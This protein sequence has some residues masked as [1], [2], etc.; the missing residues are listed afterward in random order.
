MSGQ[1]LQRFQVSLCQIHHVDVVAHTGTVGRGVVVAPDV[2]KLP[3]AH[4]HLR[5]KG[6]QVIGRALRVLPDQP[7]GVG[8]HRVEIT[9]Y[10]NAPIR[11]AAV[12]VA[13]HVLYHQLS[14]SVGVGGGQGVV[15]GQ[16]QPLRVAVYRGRRA[17]HQ[18]LDPAFAH[19]LQQAQTAHHIVV[20]IGQRLRHRFT[21][22]LEACKV[23]HRAGATGPQCAGQGATVADIALDQPDLSARDTPHPRQ[24]L[25][26]AVAEIVEHRHVQA[27][28]EQ[29][30][31]GMAADITRAARDQHHAAVHLSA[32]QR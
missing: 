4:R 11:V 27:R 17:E 10:G 8:A 26:L 14:L 25:G 28:I 24:R 15:F 12:Q 18:R 13:Q 1:P 9:Q 6:Q 7:A 23:D 32:L 16:W 29:F 22:G 19:G 21:Y 30:H 2:H 31:A 5:H 20:V 3:P